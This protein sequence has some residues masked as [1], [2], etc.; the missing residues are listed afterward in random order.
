[1]LIGGKSYQLRGANSTNLRRMLSDTGWK[2][3]H[4]KT[5]GL[6]SPCDR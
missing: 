4:D 5:A 3:L 2:L 6:Y 1:M